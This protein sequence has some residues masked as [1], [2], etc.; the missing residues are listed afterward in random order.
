MCAAP[1]SP[2]ALDVGFLS[3]CPCVE[4]LSR[5]KKL[6]FL[7]SHSKAAKIYELQVKLQKQNFN[8]LLPLWRSGL[9]ENFKGDSHRTALE[10]FQ[11]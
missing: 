1:I 5:V 7:Q 11:C 4:S 10:T 2:E 3:V 9:L 6:R 8:S